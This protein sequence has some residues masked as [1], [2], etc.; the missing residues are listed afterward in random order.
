MTRE[1]LYRRIALE[2]LTSPEQLDQLLQ[3][4]SAKLWLA[5]AAA[6]ILVFAV[7]GWA[8][9]GS[10][11]SRVSGAG[12]LIRTGGVYD[13]AAPSSG[14][15]AD[16]AVRAG[17]VVRAG[18]V[19]ARIEQ[20]A[21]QDDLQDAHA[22]LAAQ[23]RRHEALVRFTQ[24]EDSLA[25]AL[26]VRE[27]EV[28]ERSLVAAHDES[29]WLEAKVRGQRDLLASGLIRREELLAS[30]QEL[31][32]V[33]IRE[34]QLRG[35]LQ[36]LHLRHLTNRTERARQV[37]ESH[38]ERLEIRREI[39]QLDEEISMA[40]LVRSRHTGRILEV[41]AENGALGQQGRPLMRLDRLEADVQSLEAVIYIPGTSGKEVRR[42]MTVQLS[43]ANVKREE[44]GYMIGVV[45]AVS[46]FPATEEAMHRTLKNQNLVQM[47]GGGGAPYEAFVSL[48]LDPS[49]PDGYAWSS[50]SPGVP[51][52]SGTICAVQITTRLRR[53][54]ELV[55]PYLRRTVGV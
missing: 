20:P 55:A 40:T 34:E 29:G 47:L 22:R 53:P 35:E 19:V 51:I 3:V 33:S 50:E 12:V 4:T 16:I 18:Q 1:T 28:I 8:V 11:P 13:I 9:L 36:Q 24:T 45:S 7:G 43:P 27:R 23:E 44:H 41:M 17:D 52:Q 31:A 46:E 49:S 32:A 54:I 38:R 25:S 39:E 37:A 30:E 48:R 15:I 26:A 6:A 21:L 5:L 2:R 42:G 10:V 14:L